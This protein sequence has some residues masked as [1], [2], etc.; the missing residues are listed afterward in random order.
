MY[1]FLFSGK[2]DK[3]Q[4]RVKGQWQ[5][6]ESGPNAGEMH[7]K[8]NTLSQPLAAFRVHFH[9]CI[10]QINKKKKKKRAGILDVSVNIFL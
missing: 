4:K 6:K 1:S 2:D 3:C 8:E 9:M 10:V 7:I 5:V